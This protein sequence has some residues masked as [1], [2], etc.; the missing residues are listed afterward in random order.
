MKGRLIRIAAICLLLTVCLSGCGGEDPPDWEEAGVAITSPPTP[1]GPPT[2]D[3]L[4]VYL[5]TSGSMAGYVTPNGQNVFG[6]TLRALR[7]VATSFKPAVQVSVRHVEA[8][9]KDPDPDGAL[10]LQKASIT[11]I[12][13]GGDTDLAG[14][15][16][17]FAPKYAQAAAQSSPTKQANGNSAPAE[18]SAADAQPLARYHILIT[19]GVQSTKVQNTKQGCLKGSDATCVREKIIE[20]IK[21]GWGGYVI[22]LRSQFHGNIYSQVNNDAPIP[23]NTT[24]GNWKRYRPFY[25]YI[26]SPDRAALDEF[27][28]VLRERLRPIA[29]GPEA[30]RVL[31]LTSPYATT[32][33]KAEI[34]VPAESKDAVEQTN[35][36]GDDPT[37]FTLEVNSDR[38]ETSPAPITIAI[39]MPWS[40]FVRDSGTP[41]ELTKLLRWETEVQHAPAGGNAAAEDPSRRYAVLKLKNDTGEPTLDDQGRITLQATVGWPRSTAKPGWRVYR[42]Q[43]RL[44]LSVGHEPLPWIKRWSTDLDTTAEAGDRTL[45][46]E[47][48][49]TGL[50]RNPILEQQMVTT[51]YLRV[52]PQ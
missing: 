21:Q 13:H 51:M 39:N 33:A 42:L 36:Q 19:D 3:Q 4:V 26:F 41:E 44:D 11:N 16:S 22:G 52:G 29:S 30:M 28:D 9:V 48:V 12:Y 5:D 34:V 14:A 45:N 35:G 47:S 2:T 25:L 27:V 7:D 40:S 38:E 1:P 43:S 46:L 24:E 50:W 20:L 32:A 49:L 23:Y 18:E 15:F 8:V 37:R 17:S 31:A 6:L 10:A